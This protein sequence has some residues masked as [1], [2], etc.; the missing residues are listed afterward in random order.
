MDLNGEVDP[1]TDQDRQTRDRDQRQVDAEQRNNR[2]GPDHTDQHSEERQ[3][4]PADLE[5]Q[6]EHDGHHHERG[7]TQ[8]D[9]PA[10]EVVVDLL[11]VHGRPGDG[12][13]EAVQLEVVEDGKDRVGGVGLLIEVGVAGEDHAADRDT[14]RGAAVDVGE[15][16]PQRTTDLQLVASGRF[17]AVPTFVAKD[18]QVVIGR[19]ADDPVVA[20][21]RGQTGECGSDVGLAS[22]AVL[23]VAGLRR[24]QRVGADA[25]GDEVVRKCQRDVRGDDSVHIV[26][27]AEFVGD[28]LQRFEVRPA[29]QVGDVVTLAGGEQQDD[30]LASEVVLE[31][32]IVDRNLRIRVEVTVLAG[33]EVHARKA[34]G[35]QHH[36]E[37]HQ[38][39]RHQ[40]PFLPE[41]PPEPTPQ[42]IHRHSPIPRQTRLGTWRRFRCRSGFDPTNQTLRTD[43]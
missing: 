32:D 5:D 3:Q 35:G 43:G 14:V 36:R 31:I 40:L 16:R 21:D 25:A 6:G 1:E 37:R 12:E 30:R 9:H 15:R 27:R 17:R 33:R 4:P 18:Q 11:E 23:G 34:D 24:Q 10:L 13:V 7:Q 28:R 22:L 2:E 19:V 41:L 38:C 20:R 26:D 39:R 8:G 29:E 42:T